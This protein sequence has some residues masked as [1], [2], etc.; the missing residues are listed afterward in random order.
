ML[1]SVAVY[2]ILVGT[3]LLGLIGVLQ[4]GESIDPPDH[5]GGPWSI[6]QACAGVPAGTGL[7]VSQSGR[8]LRVKFRD[9][10][11]GK[12]RLEA[13]HLTATITANVGE[14]SGQDLAVDARL[15]EGRLVGTI[16]GPQCSACPA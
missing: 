6:E 3:P 9:G 12:G 14:C 2:L 16:Q 8:F 10:V 11:A 4:W 15:E 7:D 13:D 1:K 5:V